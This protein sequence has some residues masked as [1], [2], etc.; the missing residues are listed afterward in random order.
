[1]KPETKE[2]FESF[3]RTIELALGVTFTHNGFIELL[4]FHE[5]QI[6]S[7]IVTGDPELRID[8]N[9]FRASASKI[10]SYVTDPLTG[11]VNLLIGLHEI[12]KRRTDVGGKCLVTVRILMR[13]ISGKIGIRRHRLGR[14]LKEALDDIGATLWGMAQS[15]SHTKKRRSQSYTS[16]IFQ[17]DESTVAR[18]REKIDSCSLTDCESSYGLVNPEVD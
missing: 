2:Q 3:K 9:Q 15:E 8:L 4:L 12:L 7:L 14:L 13:E 11:P 5:E 1:M 10:H 18:L 6:L 16:M 17:I